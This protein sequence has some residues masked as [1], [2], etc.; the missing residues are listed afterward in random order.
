MLEI[1]LALNR[2]APP[3]PTLL[4]PCLCPFSST[5][6]QLETEMILKAKNSSLIYM[7]GNFETR[8]KSCELTKFYNT[9]DHSTQKLLT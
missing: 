1:A 6:L 7:V 4:V 3:P 9:S 8:K 5:D 2:S